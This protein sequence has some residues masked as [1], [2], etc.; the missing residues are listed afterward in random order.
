[1]N[2][3]TTGILL[4]FMAFGFNS[5]AD[6]ALLNNEFTKV[7]SKRYEQLLKDN[8]LPGLSVAVVDNFQTVFTYSGGHRDFAQ[9]EQIDLATAFNAASISKPVIATL[10]VMLSE[11]G[12]LDLD[13]PVSTYLKSWIL[14]DSE[15]S[16][17]PAITLRHLLSHT[18]GSTH[19]GYSSRYLGETIP[20]AAEVLNTYKGEAIA[21]NFTPGE[22]WK[23]SGGGFLIAQIALEDVTGKSL[24]ELGKEMLFG[25]LNMSNTTFYQHGHDE[26]PQNVAKAHDNNRKVIATG[27]PICPEAACG[28]WT[29]AVD[30]AK[31]AIEIQKALAGAKTKVISANVAKQ[32]VAVQSTRLTGGWGLGWMRNQAAGNLDWFSHSG[33]NHGTG[34]LV[35]ATVEQGRGIFIFGNGAYRARIKSI[36]QVVD[37]VISSLDWKQEIEASH[38]KP[39]KRLVEQ[40]AGDYEN[41]TPHHFSPFAKKVRVENRGG[42]LFLLNSET[43][44]QFLPLIHV[45]NNKFM[46][47]QL[48]NSQIGFKIEQ[49]GDV[50][51]TLEQ[52]STDLVS[53][54]LLKTASDSVKNEAIV[55]E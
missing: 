17:G 47:D 33:Y 36:A 9:Q 25:P 2:K 48:V 5:N 11:Q 30:M 54:A 50:F 1:M 18:S 26:F 46:V 7:A 32:L 43:H 51:I 6:E 40:V 42:E 3:I 20:S 24:A 53:N 37:S 35:M 15:Y 19:S 45:G 4:L 49:S 27:I 29:N 44:T 10:A 31:L 16:K 28:L 52:S 8:Q 23:Y 34:G 14:P 21:I 39:S 22:D 55:T 12:K 13:A 38:L 41:L